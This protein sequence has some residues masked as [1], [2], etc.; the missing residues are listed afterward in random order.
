MRLSRGELLKGLC[1]FSAATLGER[2][3]AIRQ[4]PSKLQVLE[5]CRDDLSAQVLTGKR[6]FGEMVGL[7]VKFSQG[8]PLAHLPL[9]KELGVRWVRDGVGWAEMEPSPGE[10]QPFPS[11]FQ[12]RLD[13]YR[14]N[15]IG[16]DFLLCYDNPVAYPNTP[17][18][19]HHS[20]D[21]K[22]FGRYAVAVAKQLKAAGVR[23]V[24]EIWNEPHNFVLAKMFG[25]NWNGKPPSPWVDQYVD[26][27]RE[28]VAQVKAY[29]SHIHLLDDDD[30]WILHYWFLEKGLPSALDGISFHPYGGLIPEITA[31][32]QNTDWC[33]PFTVVDADRSFYSAVRRLR[34]QALKKMGKVPALWVT[35]WGWTL[36]DK[37]LAGPATEEI[38]KGYV[39][40]AFL[41]AFASGVEVVCWFSSYDSVDGPI[42]LIQ[43]DGKPRKTFQAFKVM[44]QELGAYR[45]VSHKVGA[46]HR[47]AGLQVYL[48]HG[49]AGY[50][51]VAWN[52]DGEMPMVLHTHSPDSVQIV[53]VLGQP[54]AATPQPNGTL[55]FPLGPDPVYIHGIAENTIHAFAPEPS[56][57]PTFLE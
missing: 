1:G 57:K 18:N 20:A 19:P 25:G 46:D 5:E 50:K 41:T 51:L 31:V 38:L 23:F 2:A 7:N 29:D 47:N 14:A 12:Q 36:G 6:T 11:A 24:L 42:G 54:L 52:I 56:P 9:L 53:D 8:E 27:V 30:M 55:R 45:L 34:V 49:P 17:S 26:M 37:T 4:V 39:P 35:E 3:S 22:A 33:K 13:Y 28:A 15:N 48:L 16:I 10:Y 21:P 43:N 44:S 32:D 40:R